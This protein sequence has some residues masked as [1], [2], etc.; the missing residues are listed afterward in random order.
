MSTLEVT[1]A[2]GAV[3]PDGED[4]AKM[5]GG[6]DKGQSRHG[7]KRSRLVLRRSGGARKTTQPAVVDDAPTATKQVGATS[8]PMRRPTWPP[9]GGSDPEGR[10]QVWKAGL[11]G[12]LAKVVETTRGV[13]RELAVMLM[14]IREQIIVEKSLD[15]PAALLR[16]DLALIRYLRGLVASQL[17]GD[18]VTAVNADRSGLP[19]ALPIWERLQG[20][21]QRDLQ[22]AER[23]MAAVD[24]PRKVEIKVAAVNLANQQVVQ[25]APRK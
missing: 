15:S 12:P 18:F 22:I 17:E 11:A 23:M 4:P 1:Q 20:I 7:S 8:R 14:G 5:P 19:E 9:V 6:S 24:G 25:E 3:E 16:L 13:E 2:N 21:A 10:L